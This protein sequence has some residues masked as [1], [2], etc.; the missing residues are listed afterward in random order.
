MRQAS[1]AAL[2]GALLLVSCSDGDAEPGTIPVPPSDAA[3]TGAPVDTTTPSTGPPAST[4]VVQ[5]TEPTVTPTDASP[6]STSTTTTEVRT[7]TTISERALKAK[8]AA[9]Y[10]RSAELLDELASNPTLE[11]L[12]ARLAEITAPGTSPYRNIKA[13]ISGMVERNERVINGEPDYSTAEAEMVKLQGD[14][15][16]KEAVVTFCVVTNRVRIDEGGNPQPGTGNLAAIRGS[17]TSANTGESG[18]LGTIST[19]SATRWLAV[20]EI[21][22]V[23]TDTESA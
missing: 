1:M 8:I 4:A 16:H 9:D 18:D 23:I 22:A 5:Q 3:T 12:D 14:P 7:T 21:Q 2:A 17:A 15:P 19:T 6:A 20:A 10:E 11:N 13:F